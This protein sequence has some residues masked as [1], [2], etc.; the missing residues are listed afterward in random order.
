MH[1]D[2]GRPGADCQCLRVVVNDEAH[3]LP[4][5]KI[6]MKRGRRKNEDEKIEGR[7]KGGN[8]IH[9]RCLHART[10]TDQSIKS[11]IFIHNMT[12]I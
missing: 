5:E 2:F 4:K 3:A 8:I 11:G 7:K 12:Y 10:K 9:T 1:G 6:I